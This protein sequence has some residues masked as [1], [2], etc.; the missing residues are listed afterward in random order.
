MGQRESRVERA[1]GFS[2]DEFF[3]TEH[4]I[5]GNFPFWRL[6]N[7]LRRGGFSLFAE[8]RVSF[9]PWGHPPA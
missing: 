6:R 3:E 8:A 7:G 4:E 2:G 1:R 9:F 5:L